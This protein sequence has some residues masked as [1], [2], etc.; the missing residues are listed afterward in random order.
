MSDQAPGQSS[1]GDLPDGTLVTGGTEVAPYLIENGSR[2]L[3]PSPAAFCAGGFD[4]NAVKAVA[5]EDLA[6]IPLGE[7]LALTGGAYNFASGDVFLGAG[8]YMNTHG[9]LDTASGTVA[10]MTRIWTITWFGGYHGSVHVI[11]ADQNDAPVW[12][13]QDHRYGVDGTWIG[14]SDRTESWFESMN[15]SWARPP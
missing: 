10:A 7:P 15:P 8:H 2:R 11:F 9:S 14:T 1:V 3:I 5:P 6:S 4:K 13:S 12:Q